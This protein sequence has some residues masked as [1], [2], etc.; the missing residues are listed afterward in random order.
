MKICSSRVRLA[1]YVRVCACVCMCVQCGLVLMDFA[2]NGELFDAIIK[3][4]EAGEKVGFLCYSILFCA[5]LVSHFDLIFF[6]IIC[7]SA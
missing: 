7:L 3:V 4:D 2:S 1:L 5:P 6:T